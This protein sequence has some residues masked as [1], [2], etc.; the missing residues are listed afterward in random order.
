MVN[1]AIDAKKTWQSDADECMGFFNGP[2]G[3]LYATDGI[4][5]SGKFSYSKT[6]TL[7]QPSICMTVNKV[8]EAVQL[9]GPSLYHRNP[10]RTVT[11]RKLPE[12]PLEVFGNPNDP[13]SHVFVQNV[14]SSLGQET[15]QDKARASLVSG[16]INYFPQATNLKDEMRQAIDEA[17]I[18]G[19]GVL[20]TKPYQPVGSNHK[21]VGSFWDSSDN[22]LL[23]PD[24]LRWEDMKWVGQM[25]CKPVWEVEAEYGLPP[26]TVK[27]SKQSHGQDASLSAL[28]SERAH[29]ESKTNDLVVYYKIWSKMGV[30]GLL[31]GIDHKAAEADRFGQYVHLVVTETCEH[32]LNIPE[33]VWGNE[34][35]MYRRFQWDTPYW[36][37]DEWP[38][39][40]IIF[41]KVP[42]QL[43]PMSHFR[44]AIGE[45]QFINW[46]F[47]F[48][49]SK[50]YKNSRDFIATAANIDENLKNKILNSVKDFELLE[51]KASQNKHIG[52]LVQFLQHPEMNTDLFKVIQAVIDLFEKRIGLTELMYGTTSHQFRS[53]AEA[54]VKQGQL[55]VRPDDM[56][57]I[58]ED[59]A[60]NIGKKEALAARWHLSGM[61]V[62][63]IFGETF[64][65]LWDSF[66]ATSDLNALIRQL[67]YRIEAGS[68]RKPNKQKMID[69]VNQ[70][71]QLMFPFYSQM[72]ASTGMVDPFNNLVDMWGKAFDVDTTGLR[73]TA[74]PPPPQPQQNQQPAPQNGE[75]Q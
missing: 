47:S 63:S 44:P 34:A 59:A 3:F 38:F 55:S 27:G 51:F 73:L 52:E 64:G 18:K 74:P 50:V 25:C 70:A 8:A 1:A 62:T 7:P 17:L 9:F 21:V 19:I 46:A 22:L 5:G 60:S 33:S 37:D 29:R 49:I 68:A 71:M 45:L 14:L 48:L 32:P 16:I 11:P 35:E 67:Q 72:A 39:Q 10:I 54:E 12:V 26:G 66:V 69:D 2:Y 57:S 75:Q 36:A 40:E 24:A 56:A 28:L 43:W 65:R 53:A 13:Q 42:N 58:V 31:R 4:S 23:D 41:H 61:D 6:K 15:M 30:G 20:W